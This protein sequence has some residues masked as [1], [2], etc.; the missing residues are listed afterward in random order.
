LTAIEQARPPHPVY[1]DVEYPK[2]VSRLTTFFRLFMAIPQFIVV[3]LLLMALGLITLLSWFAILFTGRYPKSFFEFASG[4]MR[5]QANVWAYV[6]LLRDEYPPF[7][8]EPGDYP[9]TLDIPMAE[10]QSRFR[11]FIRAFAIVP[12]YIVLQFVMYGWYFTTF[13]SWWMIIFSGRYPRGLFKFSVGVLRWQQRQTAYLYL[14]RDEY[15]PYSINANARPGNEVVSALIGLPLFA[16]YA[17]WIIFQ[18]S[19]AFRGDTSVYVPLDSASIER[20]QPSL[21]AGSLRLTMLSY[22]EGS[23]SRGNDVLT[24]RFRAEH[25]GFT[26]AWFSASSFRLWTC[27]NRWHSVSHTTGDGSRFFL[28]S[29]ESEVTVEFEILKTQTPCQLDYL[30]VPTMKFYLAAA[31]GGAVP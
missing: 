30:G 11:L 3:Y 6:G 19:F 8:F 14:L 12:N 7:S 23:S 26:P 29:G 9:V 18:S 28:W 25:D 2:R 13:L 21:H 22:G 10:R 31:D 15:P 17:G 24:F 1:F 4:V 5:W 20:Q 16:L 27:D